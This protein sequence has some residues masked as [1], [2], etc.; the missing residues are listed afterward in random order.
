V[1]E[2][3]ESKARLMELEGMMEQLSQGTINVSGTIY[4][5]VKITIGSSSLNIME[6]FHYATFKRQQGEVVMTVYEKKGMDDVYGCSPH[7]DA[8]YC[9]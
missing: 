8:P 6:E 4:P 9:K 2:I 5:G 1:Q 3:A 7:R